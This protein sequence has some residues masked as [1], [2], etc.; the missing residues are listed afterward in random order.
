[1]PA[2][3][4][5]TVPPDAPIVPGVKPTG[6]KRARQSGAASGSHLTSAAN[7]LVSLRFSSVAIAVTQVGLSHFIVPFRG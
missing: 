3:A 5:W 6:A 1:M 4:T 7:S 2:H